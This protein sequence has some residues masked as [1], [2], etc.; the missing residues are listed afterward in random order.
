MILARK[1][2][3]ALPRSFVVITSAAA[4]KMSLSTTPTD[5]S[6][7][8]DWWIPCLLIQ[9]KNYNYYSLRWQ[10]TFEEWEEGRSSWESLV[11]KSKGAGA[12]LL[13]LVPLVERRGS[14]VVYRKY[15]WKPGARLTFASVV[16]EPFR[17]TLQIL[18]N[19]MLFV[20]MSS[21]T[22]YN[23]GKVHLSYISW[24]RYSGHW[25]VSA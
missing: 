25:C 11:L 2:S 15:I 1:E 4:N 16:P 20:E 17:D 9:I 19:M 24:L 12:L 6:F 13:P 3:K 7:P 18:Y 10:E 5:H 22:W 8:L 21:E 23:K 14:T